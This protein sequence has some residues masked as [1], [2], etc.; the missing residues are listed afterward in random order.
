VVATR[1]A[2]YI[3]RNIEAHSCNHSCS[4]KAMSITYSECGWVYGGVCVGVNGCGWVYG[5]VCMCGCEWVCVC[6]FVSG[7]M[8]VCGCEWLWVGVCG[9]VWL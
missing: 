1:Q 8:G 4:G 6:V 2:I 3:Y 5:G 7:C 9:W